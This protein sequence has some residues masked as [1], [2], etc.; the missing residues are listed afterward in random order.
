MDLYR[1]KTTIFINM[2]NAVR[3]SRFNKSHIVGPSDIA[4]VPG[5]KPIMISLQN[6]GYN[7]IGLSHQVGLGEKRNFHVDD[8]LNGFR[9]TNCLLGKG[10]FDNIYWSTIVCKY[11]TDVRVITHPVSDLNLRH[12]NCLIVGQVSTDYELALQLRFDFVWA[13]KFFNHV[14]PVLNN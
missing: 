11:S 9:K 13:T 7:V 4:L 6:Q 3:R 5:R 12:K 14:V 10:R 1:R 2:D 8:L